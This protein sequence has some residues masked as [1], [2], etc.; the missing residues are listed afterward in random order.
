MIEVKDLRKEFNEVTALNSVS[1]QVDEGEILAYP[2]PHGVGKTTTINI[3]ATMLTPT[4]GKCFIPSNPLSSAWFIPKN[5]LSTVKLKRHH[6]HHPENYLNI[7]FTFEQL[8]ES[9]KL[10]KEFI[11][12]KMN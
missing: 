3:L 12:E 4:S 8:Q 10:M 1:F 5:H 6:I 9:I 11:K 2:G 7:R